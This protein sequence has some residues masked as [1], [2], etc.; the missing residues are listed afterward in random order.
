M[1]SRGWGQLKFDEKTFANGRFDHGP[2]V[3]VPGNVIW[4]EPHIDLYNLGS[5]PTI[6]LP[7]FRTAQSILFV[8]FFVHDDGEVTAGI[9]GYDLHKSEP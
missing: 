9:F 7:V 8:D 4:V 5:L 6:P 2:A 1:I 3:T